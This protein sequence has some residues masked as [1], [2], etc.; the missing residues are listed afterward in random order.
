MNAMEFIELWYREHL[1]NGRTPIDNYDELKS[2]F[3]DAL[4]FIKYPTGSDFHFIV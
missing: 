3:W 2:Y 4:G 1:K